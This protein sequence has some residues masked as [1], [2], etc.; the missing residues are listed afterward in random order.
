MKLVAACTSCTQDI[1]VKP[2]RRTRLDL[3]RVVGQEID[4]KCPHCSVEA[5]YPLDAVE[6]TLSVSSSLGLIV[7]LL[8]SGVLT[9]FLWHLGWMSL[10]T[11]SLPAVIYLVARK[12]EDRRIDAFNLYR[13]KGH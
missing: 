8:I 6:A 2:T 1:R 11:F 13:L 9:Y 5:T 4:L 10:L 12:E 3:S 7:G